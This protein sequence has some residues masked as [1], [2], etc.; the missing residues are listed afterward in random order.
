MS[1]SEGEWAEGV[2]AQLAHGLR[3][4]KVSDEG[5]VRLHRRTTLPRG[6][7]DLVAIYA[8]ATIPDPDRAEACV[9]IWCGRP[10]A[11]GHVAL[12][13]PTVISE[14]VW[15]ATLGPSVEELGWVE[16][17]PAHASEPETGE[18]EDGQWA[19]VLARVRR[20]VA[21]LH[22][23]GDQ[24]WVERQGGGD[25][26]DL[27]LEAHVEAIACVAGADGSLSIVWA[28]QNAGKIRHQAV[29]ILSDSLGVVREALD[30]AQRGGDS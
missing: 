14:S 1:V 8:S 24:V 6:R 15:R 10:D 27:G 13:P 20:E 7:G 28:W 11:A 22:T 29:T 19:G 12:L 16:P 5:T 17:D 23:D 9:L 3:Q 25:L 30:C 2:K 26:I 4:A 21:D 18:A